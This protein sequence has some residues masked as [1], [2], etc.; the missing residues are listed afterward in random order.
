M[1]RTSAIALIV[2]SRKSLLAD[3]EERMPADAERLNA[4][5]ADLTRLLLDV[6]AGR[7]NAFELNQPTRMRVF[8]SA[9]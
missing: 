2:R 6:R 3:A 1:S 9:D 5:A 7:V 8:I 4:A